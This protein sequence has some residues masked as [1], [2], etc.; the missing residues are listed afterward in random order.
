MTSRD[1]LFAYTDQGYVE[2]NFGFLKDTISVNSLLLKSSERIEAPGLV[3]A[4]SLLVW[5]LME[6]TTRL[7][8]K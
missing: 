3:P 1:L 2:R 8:L 7:S 5:R 4:L 6:R